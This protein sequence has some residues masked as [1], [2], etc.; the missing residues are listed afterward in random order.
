MAILPIALPQRLLED[1]CRRWKVRELALFGSVLRDDFRPGSDIDVLVA[2]APEARWSL[3]DMV[4]MQEALERIVGRK[5]DLVEREAV[6][7]SENY[8]RRNRILGS[9]LPIYVAG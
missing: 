3:F 6:E 5:I 7:R 2:F 1:F 8:I 4:E 9:L